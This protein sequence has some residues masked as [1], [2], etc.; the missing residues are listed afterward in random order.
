MGFNGQEFF[1]IAQYGKE[2]TKGTAV[3]ATRMRVGVAPRI[4]TDSKPE[5]I[6]EQYGVR[7][8]SRRAHIYERLYV[9]TLSTPHAGFQQLIM[10]FSTGLKGATSSEVTPAQ[11]D[12][13]FVFTPNLTAAAGD[14]A[15]FAVTLQVGDDQQGWRVPY[16]MTD[17]ITIKGKVSQ[18]GGAAP[19][20]LEQGIFGRFIEES[21]LT[22]SL[23]LEASTP[24]NAKLAQL[25]VDTAWAS[26][27]T[28][29][30]SD[31]LDEFTLEIL[32]GVHPVFRGSAT[33]YFNAHREGIISATGTFVVDTQLRDELLS[34]QQAGDL[35]IVR[36]KLNGPQIGTGTNH[37]LTVDIGGR[38]ED[39]TPRDNSDRGDNLA[40]LALH[41]QYDDTGAKALQVELTSNQ[42]TI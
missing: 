41:M 33:N 22:S 21:A 17:R 20:S 11:G 35:Q 30:L 3:A 12:Y 8:S 27:G 36:L 24:V 18:D 29:E 7:V 23:A 2:T 38:W 37:N 39:V 6:E 16:M 13:K 32:T 26:V 10:P 1:T 34:S 31:A 19:V 42:Q 14:N 15:P 5:F 4:I 25:Y 40:T 28:N 9:N